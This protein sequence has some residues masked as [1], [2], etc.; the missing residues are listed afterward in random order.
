MFCIASMV[1]IIEL[2]IFEI[3][4]V[5]NIDLNVVLSCSMIF[6]AAFRY[7]IEC[8]YNL[9][10]PFRRIGLYVKCRC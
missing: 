2:I 10:G 4:G 7:T 5:Q 3:N 9:T 1:R 8:T 6:K